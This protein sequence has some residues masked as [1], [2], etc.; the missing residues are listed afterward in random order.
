[1]SSLKFLIVYQLKFYFLNLKFFL[2]NFLLLAI[3]KYQEVQK[4]K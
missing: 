2:S 4:N 1:M 3:I